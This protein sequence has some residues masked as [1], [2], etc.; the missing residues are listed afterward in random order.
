MGPRAASHAQ[1]QALPWLEPL[2]PEGLSEGG[3]GREGLA[4]KGKRVGSAKGPDLTFVLG[5]P[6]KALHREL[7]TILCLLGVQPVPSNFTFLLPLCLEVATRLGY[8]NH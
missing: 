7:P 8:A 6:W 4:L 2:G 3:V 5:A 1:A